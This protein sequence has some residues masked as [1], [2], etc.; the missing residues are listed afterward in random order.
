MEDSEGMVFLLATGIGVIGW[1]GFFWSASRQTTSPWRHSGF[2]P[3]LLALIGCGSLIFFVLTRWASADVVNAPFYVLF[4]LALGLAWLFCCYAGFHCLGVSGR[5]DAL[6]RGNMAATSALIGALC[7][8]ALCF[9]GGNI[10]DGP[11]WWVVVFS[12]G[13]ATLCLFGVTWILASY[14]RVI[15]A[16]VIE[17]DTAAGVRF[18]AFLI[19]SG[20][21]LGR[22]AAGDWSSA[23]D[24]VRDQTLGL[25]VVVVVLLMAVASEFA[26]RRWSIVR[27]PAQNLMASSPAALYLALAAVAVQRQGWPT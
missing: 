18:A 19:A 7:G 23:Y 21:L 26:F 25:P 5:D 20:L 8:S 13:V 24:A 22:G 10:G 16:I 14:T 4:Y 12:A 6:E 2:M 17:R 15:D 3:L 9:A 11:G 27:T 1:V